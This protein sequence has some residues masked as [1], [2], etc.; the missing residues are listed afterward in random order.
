LQPD[1][2]IPGGGG[3]EVDDIAESPLVFSN[4]TA[5]SSCA[6][7][8]GRSFEI[9]YRQVTFDHHNLFAFAHRKLG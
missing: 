5:K 8:S 4:P 2:I 6:T 1:K 3:L 7:P 9:P